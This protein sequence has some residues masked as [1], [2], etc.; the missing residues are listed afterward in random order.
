MRNDGLTEL[1]FFVEASGRSMVRGGT[2]IGVTV[3]ILTVGRRAG[4]E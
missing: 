3:V 1:G 2:I 4:R